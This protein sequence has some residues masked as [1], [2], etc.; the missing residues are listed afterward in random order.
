MA[1][2]RLDRLEVCRMSW[3]LD[4]SMLGEPMLGEP[5]MLR[6]AS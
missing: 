6:C 2:E 5:M 4:W 1:A 3:S